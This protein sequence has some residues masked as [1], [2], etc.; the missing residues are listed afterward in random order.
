MPVH[1]SPRNTDTSCAGVQLTQKRSTKKP[2]VSNS[3]TR[4]ALFE[5]SV[6]VPERSLKVTFRGH[7]LPDSICV[8]SL[9]LERPEGLTPED[10][11][12]LTR[13][14]LTALQRRAISQAAI[15]SLHGADTFLAGPTFVAAPAVVARRPDGS[16]PDGFSRQVAAAYERLVLTSHRPNVALA[17]EAGVPV[18]TARR[19]VLE[20]RRRGHLPPGERGRAT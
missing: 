5:E 9:T 19:W 13:R 11:A 4:L 16:D 10:V 1:D 14:E 2:D 18:A 12:D 6:E 7:R 20:A 17:E 8:T 15:A 3:A